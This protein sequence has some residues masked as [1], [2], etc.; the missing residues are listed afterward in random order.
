MC[1]VLLSIACDSQAKR[2]HRKG[3]RESGAEVSDASTRRRSQSNPF[4]GVFSQTE[5]QELREVTRYIR[6]PPVNT[7]RHSNRVHY[8]RCNEI[9]VSVK[10]VLVVQYSLHLSVKGL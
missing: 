8:G 1:V 5:I 4:A 3:R 6:P 10:A 9:G 2:K 7:A